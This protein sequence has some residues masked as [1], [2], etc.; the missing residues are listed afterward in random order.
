MTSQEWDK[1]FLF[2]KQAYPA[3]QPTIE[4]ALAWFTELQPHDA[5]LVLN[6]VRQAGVE[7]NSQFPPSLFQIV[8]QINRRADDGLQVD[9]V[10]Q[11]LLKKAVSGDRD[12][13]NQCDEVQ[14]AVTAI[15]GMHVLETAS[16]ERLI[17]L[18]KD[19]TRALEHFV[20]AKNYKQSTQ[21]FLTGT[22]GEAVKVLTGGSNA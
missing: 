6:A 15:G 8:G 19:F 22:S 18:K 5:K 13:N 12:L 16:H 21:R 4:T 9:M 10:W 3:W 2:M 7:L 11:K 1:I 20:D 14:R 17:W